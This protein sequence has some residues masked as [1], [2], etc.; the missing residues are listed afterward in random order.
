MSG[1]APQNQPTCS[2]TKLTNAAQRAIGAIRFRVSEIAAVAKS[3][4]GPTDGHHG[5][6]ADLGA[7]QLESRVLLS[8]TPLAPQTLDVADI[9][10]DPPA[11]IDI[12]TAAI[13][14]AA[15]SQT[16]ATDDA[17]S[18]SE[19]Q[20]V[21][22]SVELVFVDAKAKD[23]DQLIADLAKQDDNDGR[24][25]EIHV[26]D[27]SQ[28]GIEQI[29]RVLANRS[30]IDAIQFVSHGSEGRVNL[31][32]TW[33]SID[34]LDA[35]A[36]EIASWNNSLRDGAD[37][38]FY[39]CD[40]AATEDG[41]SLAD[42]IGTLTECDVAAS[43]DD[44]GH[45]DYG[46]DWD[47]EYVVGDV[48]HAVAFT[49]DV[50]QQWTGKLAT[51]TVDT[52]ADVVDGGD[53]FLSLREAIIQANSTGD[54]IDISTIGP[55]TFVLTRAGTGEDAAL[56]GDLDVIG[57]VTIF[58]L[59]ASSTI[60][61]ANGIDRVF[62]VATGGSLTL[63]D[64]TITGGNFG[65]KGGGIW[66][67]HTSSHLDLSRAIVDGN[68]AITGAGIYNDGIAN[69]TDVVIKNNGDDTLGTT[70]GG[71]LHNKEIA[72]LTRVA[73]FGNK[74]NF[75][76]GIH[77]DN[78]AVSLTLINVTVSS[79]FAATEGGGIY[80]QND[81]SITNS[82]IA[83][84]TSDGAAGLKIQSGTVDLQ[85]T[86]IASNT[87]T[88][89]F[90]DVEGTVNS[91][92]TNI[93][94]DS[95]GGSGYD[96]SDLLDVDPNL[97]VLADNGGETPTHAITTASA[98][99]NAGSAAGAPFDD[100]RGVT[101][102]AAPDIGAYEYSTFLLQST[103]EFLVNTTTAGTQVT[104]GD[105]IGGRGSHQAV[106]ADSFG[107]YVVVWSDSALDGNGWGIFAQRFDSVGNKLGAEF[108]VNTN[109]LTDEYNA[110]VASDDSGRFVVAFT[111]DD[112]AG[113]G[114]YIRRFNADGT[115]IDAADILVNAGQTANNQYNA[116][117]AVN[118]TGEMVIAWQEDTTGIYARTFDMTS[119]AAADQLSTTLITVESGGSVNEPSVGINDSGRYVVAW[120]QG[121][122]LYARR[123]DYGNT[124]ALSAKHDLTLGTFGE[125][126]VV[127]AVQEDNDFAIAYRSDIPLFTGVW[128]TLFQSDGTAYGLA[129]RASAQSTGT[130]PSIGMSDS[131]DYV[132][133][134][135][136]D[137][138]DG[139]GVFARKYNADRNAIGSAF[140]VN[141]STSLDQ[142]MASVA[143]Q[144]SN[145]FVVVWSGNGDQ[146]GEVDDAGVFARQYENISPTFTTLSSPVDTTLKD[147][148]VEITFSGLKSAGDE[149]DPDGVIR[150]F[151]VKAVTTGTLK[152]GA[153]TGT[154][155]AWAAGTNDTI[156]ANN[157][158]YWTPAGGVT[159]TLNAFQV[160][161][162]DH[163][164]AESSTN[165]TA[166]VQVNSLSEISGAVYEDVDGDGD[167]LDDGVGV[168]GVNV[169]IYLD[170]GSVNG[171]IDASDSLFTT[172]TT[173]AT[174]SYTLTGLV[175]GTYWVVVDSASID[176]SAGF[177]ATFSSGD[178]WAE[179]TY[180]AAGS[181]SFSGSYSYS[182]SAG[183]FYGGMQS[184]TSDDASAL[185]SAEHVTRV[186]VAGSDVTG[187]DSG[188]SFN[189]IT[190]TGD[191]GAG[192]SPSIQ[193]SLRQFILNSNA[194][195]NTLYGPN[196]SQFAI[197]TTDTNYN[198]SGN[199][200]FTIT[201]TSQLPDIVD[202]VV[203]DG[204]TQAG[205][206]GTP[207][208]E[209]V[210]TSA[211]A[212]AQGLNITGD[213][214]IV[215][216]F[217]INQF[218][219]IG[220]EILGHNNRIESS[221][222]GT[223]VTG[224][225]DLGNSQ[226]GIRINDSTGNYI[227][228]SGVGNVV[229]GN[230]WSGIA[231]VGSNAANNFVQGNFVG[232]DATGSFAIGNGDYGIDIWSGTP[233]NNTIGGTTADLANVISGNG[234]AGVHIA[235]GSGNIVQGNY[236]GT[237]AT[238][239]VAIG[240]GATGSGTNN[241][242][243]S[244]NSNATNNIIGGAG[245]GNTIAHNTGVGIR[246]SGA[247]TTGNQILENSIYSNTGIGIDQV[248]SGNASRA[249]ATIASASTDG[250][251]S[252]VI[253]GSYSDAS[254]GADSV[255]V[256]Y[257]SNPANDQEG[258]TF[259]GSDTF[260]T[261]GSGNAA[262]THTISQ[263]M[264]AGQYVTAT[265]TDS[266][267]NTSEFS[268]A[269]QSVATNA[270]PTLTTLSSPVETTNE[271]TEVEIT[272]AELAAAGDENDADGTVDAFI[273][274]S[275]ASGT[276][277]IGATAGTATAWAAGT[278]DTID[279]TNNAYWTPALN[280][281]GTL[282]AFE[283]VASDD[284]GLESAANVMAQIAVTPVNDAPTLTTLASPVDT[285]PE[286][287]EVEI[288]FAE[289]VAAG[290][291]NDI[292]GTVDAFIV[293]SVASGTLRI[294]ATAGTAT[295][296]AA[297][298]NDTIDATN[299]AYWTPAL[300][301]NGTL[302][303]FAV[304]AKDNSGAESAANVMAQIAVTPVND[305]P[306]LT[307]I[308]TV[309]GGPEDQVVQLQGAAIF[310]AANE[311][312]VDNSPI[313]LRFPVATANVSVNGTPVTAATNFGIN[314][315]VTWTPT[316]NAYGI[317]NAF[318]VVAWDGVLDSGTP[319][320]VPIY[321]LPV[322]DQPSFV[323]GNVTVN[324]D[325]GAQSNPGWALFNPGPNEAYQG[326]SL[327]TVN[328]TSGAALL[329]SGPAVDTNGTLSFTPAADAN[330]VV[331][332]DI[333]VRDNGGTGNGGTDTS[334]TL[335]YTIT[336]N[337]VNDA[338]SFSASNPTTVNEDSGAQTISGW[339]SGFSAGP[340]NE[341]TQTLVSYNVSN[342]SN[343]ALF[344]VQPGV[345][346][347]GDLSFTPAADQFGTSTFDVT[348]TDNG[349]TANGGI[350]TS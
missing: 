124:T 222:V 252:I 138:A 279:S 263:T 47:L 65:D 193:G 326:V 235:G 233:S 118:A 223:D 327:Y 242:G 8:A 110:T 184:E 259:L 114:V 173:D 131:G 315:I 27:S 277:R 265:V 345:N 165:V 290:D 9:N 296:W 174:G 253:S 18:S 50:Q 301:A 162:K 187:V 142:E 346:A 248:S 278:N 190:N 67:Q 172:L 54:L 64:V 137:D 175:D 203:L 151:I 89:G 96:V 16:A 342:V 214:S 123:Y 276:L 195:D 163:S 271:D 294:G 221:Y 115:A 58:G 108:Q 188:F 208:I 70:E 300:N 348:V 322:N 339:A 217:V 266:S 143:V 281:S 13:S 160:V 119:A 32:N 286:D 330:G 269:V 60:I 257:F 304:V 105:T 25:F 316:S 42:A 243:I 155:T 205:Y 251:G 154:A 11:S 194:I 273:V 104:R 141:T 299:N 293:K 139:S 227:G 74:A 295:A 226:L 46:A 344:S 128:T 238:G 80:N 204:T 85:N 134:Y 307:N 45:S 264:A 121:G 258:R 272:F 31:G 2:D 311:A 267:G 161:A 72:T 159:G 246:V 323:G 261:D 192:V 144:D 303:A 314:D 341:S 56:D 166:V 88:S 283:V 107:N 186:I 312:D 332:F 66:V 120:E 185:T 218:S 34:N 94:G 302:N 95:A 93:I 92:G 310:G 40:L 117:V 29:S 61:D 228:G 44:T 284:G 224:S 287:T 62:Q 153:T 291:E 79:N 209:L 4:V 260:S 207:I 126:S 152:I 350:D 328:V 275:V 197:P 245:A 215:R 129:T 254:L 69:L 48:E 232:T 280:A 324:E 167:V 191:D 24:S 189:V 211:G 318:S 113:T 313:Q 274:K 43:D 340:S 158:A 178:A 14:E 270:P 220:I 99:Y 78:T 84:N 36:G 109:A 147:T 202:A 140:Q 231:I 200:E 237:D 136:D 247:A 176:P 75:G 10:T 181:V 37:L 241:G 91:L 308:V 39:G 15:Q 213:N 306:T 289:L 198:G 103:S 17:N 57:N 171:E 68:F 201:P 82:T 157:N 319:I 239:T 90:N 98:A 73:V 180:G 179:Q 5:T 336:I 230:T 41:R 236:I 338:P 240:N 244:I 19:T 112:G 164:G 76:G 116:S 347:S 288:T 331:A 216:G 33:L 169:H 127:I 71:G 38:L 101:R 21:A 111:G 30:D 317:L 20:S 309:F 83:F 206:G 51:L 106:A 262:F 334:A 148:E 343:A 229:S 285:T 329:S 234:W 325:S 130:L 3:I 249:A 1:I 349:G 63:S 150:S 196:A 225:I 102:D 321:V 132:V 149:S 298:T 170:D 333:F 256:E 53:A 77:N 22:K 52:F 125:H 135:H 320:N 219:G 145:N 23:A 268:L 81:A 177:N 35:H 122:Q 292:D 87:S 183:A 133:V 12:D 212:G 335:S 28:D 168:T 59:D 55:G 255:S 146:A 297:G 199:G 156:D 86:I 100:Q 282:N 210:G 305:A 337:A 6:P 97:G 26:L 182:A 7:A 49:A 250:A